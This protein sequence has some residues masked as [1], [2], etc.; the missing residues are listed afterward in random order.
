VSRRTIRASEIG[1]YLYCHRAWWYARTGTPSHN[2]GE[3]AAGSELHR[4]HGRLALNLGC[5][6]IAAY[7]LI[8]L[9]LL[10]A[11]VYFTNQVL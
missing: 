2:Q 5:L 7:A 1:V 9:A 10:L 3:L 6:R 11:A 4:R 8:L